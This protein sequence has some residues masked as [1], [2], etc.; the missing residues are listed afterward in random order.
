MTVNGTQ[1]Y[2][3]NNRDGW[4][5]IVFGDADETITI[6]SSVIFSGGVVIPV[7]T[8]S[9]S[10][11]S[12]TGI[13]TPAAITATQF[14][15]FASVVSGAVLMGFGTTGDVTLKNRAGTD[16]LVVTANTPNV[17]MA[18]AL[19]MSGALS[20]A[21]TI[22]ATS[23]V[24]ASAFVAYSA[25]VIKAELGNND[26]NTGT[27]V[28]SEAQFYTG[29]ASGDTSFN[30][31][32][33]SA[34][35]N[36]A[37]ALNLNPSGGL[38]TTGAGLT[39]TGALTGVTTASFSDAITSTGMQP[40]AVGTTPGT[41]GT[42]FSSTTGQGGNTTIATTGAGGKGANWSVTTGAGGT[43]AV[44]TTAGTGGAGGDYAVTTGAGA[45][46]AV[47]GAGTGTGGKGGALAFLSGVGGAVTTSTG[48]NLGGASGAISLTTAAGGA[49]ANG[50]SNTGGASGAITITTGSGG[51][52]ATAG[53]ASGSITLSTGAQ[54][55][56]AAV[57]AVIL[58]PGTLT[59]V[60]C[61]WISATVG[62][63]VF[64]GTYGAGVAQI[65]FNGMTT[66]AVA[67]QAGTLT[68]APVVGN[69]SFWMPFS[70]AG[71]IRYV[72]MW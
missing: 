32:A 58:S 51:T 50:S 38:V 20:G 19:A 46:S 22:T 69:P 25:T 40:V 1:I 70:V 4:R 42:A 71:T 67:N 55:G 34:G 59:L 61:N 16:V 29:A 3:A 47:T 13:A 53:G 7:E 14:T 37:A 57:G 9:G 49:S 48:V 66:A 64:G 43:A 52:G 26:W 41:A 27:H 23:F 45:V 60:T 10:L 30:I 17:T 56:S 21:T 72:P 2:N 36:L 12:V 28:G 35:G 65:R 5:A 15:G 39:I 68:N 31:Q 11:K 62:Q 54:T 24:S 33:L 63:V 44:A 6:N 18:G 8:F